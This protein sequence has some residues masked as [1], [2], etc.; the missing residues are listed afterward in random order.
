M[1]EEIAFGT[2]LRRQRRA[3]DLSQQAFARQVGCAAVTL[4]RIEAGTLKP[5][6]EL[7][8]LLLD[9]L[10]IPESER[11]QWISVAR[12][13]TASSPHSFPVSNK[14]QSNLPN[15]LATSD[16]PAKERSEIARLIHP[17]RSATLLPVLLVQLLGSFRLV[18]DKGPVAGVNS[19]RLQ[20]LLAFLILHADSPQ[21]R[22]HV[23]SLFWPEASEGQARNNL[24][25]FLFQLRQALPDPDRFLQV[26]TSTVFW[27]TDDQQKIDVW[28]FKRA[29]KN[30]DLYG[31]RGDE[32]LQRV[33]LGEA[34][35]VY[36]GD[37]LPELYDDWT[38]RERER[39]RLQSQNAHRKL[40]QI[41]ETQRE[42]TQALTVAQRLL[43]LD[44]L[45]EGTHVTLVRLH[46]L[47]EDVSGAR[48]VYQTAV[49]TLRRELDVEPGE[50]LRSAYSRL[51][52]FSQTISSQ[53]QVNRSLRL[54]G[55][56]S[57]WQQLQ[58]AWKRAVGGDAH[59]VLITGE[60]GIGKSRLAEE[61]FNWVMRQGFATAYSRS[62][63]VEG[64]LSL[65]PVTDLLRSRNIRSYL[66][67]LDKAWIP[68]IARLLPEL[69]VEHPELGRPAPI[70]EY[71]QRQFFFEALARGIHSREHPLLLW[72]D[73]LQWADQETLE[74]LHFLL[75]FET[76]NCLL[77]LGTV[78]SEEFPPEHPLSLLS[79]QLR[80]EDRI[81]TIE[82]SPLD[83]AETAKLAAEVQ[84][85]ALEE[86][87]ILRLFRETEGNPLFVVETIRAIGS[88]PTAN[89]H[90]EITDA[91]EAQMLPPR[92]HAVIVGRLVQ[93][94]PDARNVAEI[95]AVI[96][97]A[98]PLDLLLQAGHNDEET[99]VQA[100]TELWQKRIVREQSV[101]TFDFTHDKLREVTYLEIGTP[102]RRLIH[103]NVAYALQNLHPEHLEPISGQLAAHYESAG[104]EQQALPYYQKAAIWAQN[105]FAHNEAI[106][107]LLR[108]LTLLETLPPGKERDEQELSLQTCLGISM[109]S[110]KGYGAPEVLS[111]YSR[112]RLLCDRLQKPVT[113]PV[114]RALAIAHL[115]HTEFEEALLIGNQLL[116]RAEQEHEAM[117]LVEAHYILGVTLSWQGA[118]QASNM[119]L[120]EALARYDPAQADAH[121]ALYSQDPKA[122]CLVRQALDLACL[123]YPDQA[124]QASAAS[125]TYARELSHPFTRAYAMCWDTIHHHF[126]R[127]VQKTLELAEATMNFCSQHQLDYWFSLAL[128]FHGWALTEQAALEIGIAEM[129]KG[130]ADCEARD[131]EFLMPYFRRLVAEGYGKQ[132][133]IT[134]GLALLNDAIAQIEKTGEKWCEAEMFRIKGELLQIQ[135]DDAD[136]E[137]AFRYAIEIAG[138]Q[139]AKLLQLRAALSL[140]RLWPTRSRPKDVNQQIASLYQWF[141]EGFDLS[142]LSAARALITQL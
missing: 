11:S 132:G 27:K 124:N 14:P 114:L 59:M 90:T 82:L 3:L 106:R 23:A 136:A 100:L 80:M 131:V 118:F 66:A 81:S 99:V 9:K 112:A 135:G 103:R 4:R 47:N 72:I 142:D 46:A 93:L 111:V 18:Y 25:Q 123:G 113:S 15:P 78:R 52:D 10:G 137:T 133:D 64:R 70:S 89:A 77:I 122:V 49:E 129:E 54:V 20:S 43:F 125:Q 22:L 130:I 33:A 119:H 74:W 35:S 79:R 42:F 45:D 21:S 31:Q 117:L 87:D 67:S 73:D 1:Q 101:N 141:S 126:R 68:E 121:I 84:G 34:V 95:A 91:F 115:T 88:V 30:A 26:D 8:N 19:A 12:G 110:T 29:M 58:A 69:L 55:R 96:G 39:L 17:P 32:A 24:R 48:R 57:E 62:Y 60:A 44:P 36:E 92:V 16:D 139:D 98:F 116:V 38:E 128:V 138:R 108:A 97:R 61:L 63:G 75:R 13:F 86:R 50:A 107:L 127:E 5:S 71:G 105:I 65:G 56:Q 102:K 134:K 6:K 40:I 94:S 104:L 120:K 140:A 76:A 41:L 85:H 109:V 7:A 28:L 83:A 2:W 37:L 53:G 51:Q